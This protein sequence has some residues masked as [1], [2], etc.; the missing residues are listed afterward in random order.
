MAL[1]AGFPLKKGAGERV[2]IRFSQCYP[3]LKSKALQGVKRLFALAQNDF[4]ILPELAMALC[5]S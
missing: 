1:R 2:A 5:V 3:L 4:L